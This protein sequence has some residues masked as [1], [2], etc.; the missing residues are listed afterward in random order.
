MIINI[1]LLI[2]CQLDLMTYFKWLVYFYRYFFITPIF[3]LPDLI[4]GKFILLDLF[5]YHLVELIRLTAGIQ[6][7]RYNQ[8]IV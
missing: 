2:S 3:W 8:F 7:Q 1:C 6:C 4:E 5:L